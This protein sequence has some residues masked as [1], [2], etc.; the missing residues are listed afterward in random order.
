V[1]AP[2]DDHLA[3]VHDLR[4]DV[5]HEARLRDL[6][7]QAEVV[8]ARSLAARSDVLGSAAGIVAG[9]AGRVH[10]AGRLKRDLGLPADAPVTHALAHGYR[11]W[12]PGLLERV[13]GPFA[14]VVWDT[15]GGHGLL[16]QDQLGG[17]SLFTFAD[18]P[19][20]YFATEV[21]L[22]L[23]LLPRRPAPDDVALAYHLLDHSV[24]DGRTVF[25]GVERLGAGRHMR[26]S[27]AARSAGRHWAP[28]YVAP[29]SA[30][31]PELAA[32]LR[33]ELG[34]AVAESVPTEGTSA[35]L[36]SGGLDSSAVTAMAA[37][38]AG[39]LRAVSAA[40][41]GDPAI[42]E[43]SWARRVAAYTGIG[44]TSVD[45]TDPRPLDAAAEYLRTWQLPL[46]APGIVIE[47][48]PIAA[49]RSMGATVALDG[50]GGDELFGAA[51]F[52]IADRLRTGRAL[53]AWRL[54][55]RYP[56]IGH[57]PA[58]RHLM[59]VMTNVGVR[60]ALSPRVH[61]RIRARRP[62]V[63]YLPD[64]L[65]PEPARLI[66]ETEDPWRW[67]RL[68]G[69]RWWASL[70][71][72]LTRGRERADI[73]DYVRRRARMGGLEARSPF[74]DLGLVE[75]ALR[76]P[77]ET[78]FDPVVSRSLLREAL[79]GVL[80]PDVLGR[81]DKSNFSGFYHRLLTTPDTLGEL[82][83]RLGTR[84]AAVSEY[85]D[86]DAFRAVYLDRP[87]TIGSPG[88]RSWAGHVWNVVTAELWLQ[89]QGA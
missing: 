22:L 89:A 73:A 28:R 68:D 69:P 14:L 8:R 21:E 71:D 37:P 26:L 16:A 54:A 84:R 81:R 33:A 74:L 87:P 4:G 15:T 67:K 27:D 30:P 77:P 34:R 3:G 63:R 47:S 19:R 72:T 38:R 1:T 80:P 10:D 85:V 2:A 45:V 13:R 75:L 62:D 56:S 46:P 12:G 48:P 17:R 66:R 50:Q 58:R 23:R 83:S 57:A 76:T 49:A 11:R 20:L 70:A 61:E 42:D 59:L 41:P 29:K 5:T 25:A 31:R 79:D 35:V 60:G 18:G 43:T 6:R 86:L 52:L 44:L 88:W 39:D 32:A 40:F 64:W 51:H 53:S 24:P 78:N 65:R 82:R 7:P 36:L 9:I 55:R